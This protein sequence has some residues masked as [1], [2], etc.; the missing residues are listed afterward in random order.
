MTKPKAKAKKVLGR[1]LGA[2]IEKKANRLP[3][4]QMPVTEVLTKDIV[5]NQFQPRLEMNQEK[6]DELA[7]SIK[8]QGII[9]P[10]IVRK[11]EDQGYELIAGERR[12][13]AATLVGLK[14]VPVVVKNVSDSKSLE[15]ALI[16]NIQR[17]DLNPME[18]ALAY[19]RLAN[20]FSLTQDEI[21]TQVGKSRT[22]VTN[23]MRLLKLAPVIQE[24]IKS[25]ELKE[26]HAK[27][28]LG[29]PD[30]K[31]QLKVMKKIIADGLSVRGVEEL[32]LHEKQK[33]EIVKIPQPKTENLFFA[34]E[35][36]LQRKFGTLVKVKHTN[37]GKGK[38][39]IEYYSTEDFERIMDIVGLTE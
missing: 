39:E 8:A 33:K 22:A 14:K 4:A 36:K 26:G 17:A 16:E 34:L 24:K 1:G 9:Q 28:L 18:S 31:M 19:Q 37:T 6:L 32:L 38:I 23:T 2:L 12:L 5:R 20:E 10:L 7:E 35:D 3:E 13:R 29:I 30:P 11:K 25:G 21:A 15:M 27:V